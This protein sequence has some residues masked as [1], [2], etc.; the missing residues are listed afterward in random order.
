[1][2][3]AM[4]MGAILWALPGTGPR[5]SFPATSP[6]IVGRGEG[7][8][9]GLDIEYRSPSSINGRKTGAREVG[10]RCGPKMWAKGVDEG[11]GRKR[12]SIGE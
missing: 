7:V 12:E 9:V 8:S 5:S 4:V 6:T 2:S 11:G 3:I 10:Q 1:M